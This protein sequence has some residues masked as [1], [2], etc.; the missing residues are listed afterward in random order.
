MIKLIEFCSY[1]GGL[2]HKVVPVDSCEEWFLHLFKDKE[3]GHIYVASDTYKILS[4]AGL[5]DMPTE[6]V[7]E[8]TI[9]MQ[10]AIERYTNKKRCT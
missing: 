4:D 7:A 1:C 6:P 5:L 2:K 3:S 10:S 9:S 8:F